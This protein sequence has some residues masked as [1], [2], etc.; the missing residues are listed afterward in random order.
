MQKIEDIDTGG[1]STQVRCFDTRSQCSLD[2]RNHRHEQKV[3]LFEKE[4][5]DM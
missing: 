2:R 1:C 5:L 3:T 4:S